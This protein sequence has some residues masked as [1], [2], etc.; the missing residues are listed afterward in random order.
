MVAAV[1]VGLQSTFLTL[2]PNLPS[3]YKL[4]VVGI[5]YLFHVGI[6]SL[7]QNTAT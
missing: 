4:I 5:F 6:F 7:R 2:L 1:L 3:A